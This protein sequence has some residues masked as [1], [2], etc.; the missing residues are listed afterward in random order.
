MANSDMWTDLVQPVELTGYARARL[1]DY[2][3]Q[4][5]GSLASFLPNEFLNDIVARF[6]VGGTGLQPVAEFLSYDTETPLASLPG[7]QRVTI[8]LPKLGL[9][10]R[11]SEYEQL[12]AKGNLSDVVLRTSVERITE[13]LVDAISDRL[14]YER[15][16]ALENAALLIDDETGF[17]QTGDWERD[18]AHEVSAEDTTAAEFWDD[19]NSDPIANLITWKEQYIATN[20]FAPGAILTSTTVLTHLQ[21]HASLRVLA[22]SLAGAPQIVTIDAVNGAL[23]AYG[24]PPIQVYDRQVNFKGTVTKVLSPEFLF[25]LPSPGGTVGGVKLGAT[26]WGTTLEASEPEYGIGELD[27]PGIV[28]GTWKTRDPIAVWVHSAAIG[29]AVLGDANLTFR[30]QVLPESS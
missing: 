6:N 21:R 17:K 9:K 5:N 16:Y 4:Q 7:A 27:R 12:R 1:E 24:L 3:R 22:S 20:G 2:E 13:R 14:E 28:V 19:A 18:A 11:V 10:M 25:M 8:E 29:L 26:Y 23:A 15:G 30:A